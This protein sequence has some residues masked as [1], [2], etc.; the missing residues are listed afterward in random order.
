MMCDGDGERRKQIIEQDQP[1]FNNAK[2][3]WT[4]AGVFTREWQVAI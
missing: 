4:S 1:A 3:E 2:Y